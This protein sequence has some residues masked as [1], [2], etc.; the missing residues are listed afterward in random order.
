MSKFTIPNNIGQIRQDNQSDIF[1]ELYETF[2][3]NLTE[4]RGKIKVSQKL[5]K[6][7]DEVTNLGNATTVNDILIWNNNYYLVTEDDIYVCSVNNDPTNSAN[8]SASGLSFDMDLSTTAVIFDGQ[9]RYSLNTDIGRWNGSGSK[10]DTWWTSDI[11]GP[12]LTTSKPHVLHVHRGGQ[13]TLFVTDDNKVHY[14]NSTAGHSTVTLQS[15][16]VASCVDSGVSAIWVGTYTETHGNAYVYE[17]YVGEQIDSVTVS[18]NAYE[19]DGRAV[20][21]LWVKDNIPYIVTERGNVQA[22]NGAGFTTIDTFP[23][24][25]GRNLDN[26]RA[27]QIQDSFYSRP[28]HPR[29]VKTYN[30]STFISINSNS[31]TDVYAVNSRFHSGIW[32]LDHTTNKLNHRFSFANDDYGSSSVQNSAPLIV[33]DNQYTFMMAGSVRNNNCGLYMTTTDTNQAW[34]VTPEITSDTVQEAYEVIYHK[35]KTLGAS[36]DVYTLY[37]NTKRDTVYGTANWMS[38]DTFTTTDDWSN[39][40]VGELIRVSHGYNGGEWAIIKEISS[41]TNTY[42]IKLNRS[43]GS[44]TETSYVYSDNFKLL[45]FDTDTLSYD[46]VNTY[47]SDDGEFKKLGVNEVSPWIQYMVIFKGDIEYRQLISKGNSKTEI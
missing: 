35:A 15:H 2:N 37:R 11:S 38:A 34:F 3:V 41:S 4:S 12:A 43:I 8:W 44:A 46:S 36:E 39:V 30:N 18:R 28:V 47:T 7:L 22:F 29:G 9:L 40:A 19:V 31:E 17:M 45:G 24:K 26:V 14:Y 1:G 21:A 6:I 13:E 32:E 10:S 5:N 42:T 33:V 23:M 16:L 25:I 27:G 20:L